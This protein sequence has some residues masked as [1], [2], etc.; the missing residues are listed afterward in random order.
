M[1]LAVA[2]AC[3]VVVWSELRQVVRGLHHLH[4][5]HKTAGIS[6]LVLPVESWVE[7]WSLW[8]RMGVVV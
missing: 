7:I 3:V 6:I 8:S 4:D 5:E 1:Y 2:G